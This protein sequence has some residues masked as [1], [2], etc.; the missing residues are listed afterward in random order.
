[1][2]TGH[3]MDLGTVEVSGKDGTE[4][5]EENERRM[6][7]KQEQH[8]RATRMHPPCNWP[9]DGLYLASGWLSKACQLQMPGRFLRAVTFSPTRARS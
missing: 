9:A 5:Q 2:P 3:G 8:E 7:G 6:R 1:M 4:E